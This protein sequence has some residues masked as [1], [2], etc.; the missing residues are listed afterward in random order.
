MSDTVLTLRVL[1]PT[2][3]IFRPNFFFFF[4]ILLNKEQ[5]PNP[6][7]NHSIDWENE[8][9]PALIN[10]GRFESARNFARSLV[11]VLEQIRPNGDTTVKSFTSYFG[12]SL[13][14]W[15]RKE[16]KERTSKQVT[17]PTLELVNEV[18][19][20]L[21]QLV[22]RLMDPNKVNVSKSPRLW[23]ARVSVN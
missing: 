14:P 16:Q 2:N 6:L 13:P 22:T 12:N 11:K 19:D 20:G 21:E 17:A 1:D 5:L 7:Y 18:L 15:Y 9:D 4:S 8:Q 3:S 10:T 23:P